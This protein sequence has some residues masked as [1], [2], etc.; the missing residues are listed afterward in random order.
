M[1]AAER[2]DDFGDKISDEARERDKRVV[3]VAVAADDDDAGEA[4][5]AIDVADALSRFSR[6]LP[7]PLSSCAN[8]EMNLRRRASHITYPQ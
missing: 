8:N 3:F 6:A 1:A 2:V 4:I 7:S 5:G